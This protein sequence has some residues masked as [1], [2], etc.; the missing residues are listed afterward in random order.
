MIRSYPCR[1]VKVTD[2]DTVHAVI[3]AGFRISV[4]HVIRLARVNAPEL[5]TVEGQTAKV[6]VMAWVA[7]PTNIGEWPFTLECDGPD[8]RDKYGRWVG[9]VLS[10]TE[11]L[12][13]VLLEAGH[14]K[15]WP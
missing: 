4:R 7:Q 14:A 1:I 10:S 5:N 8:P 12:S 6:F 15:P 11:R 3:D 2:G 9:D 13:T